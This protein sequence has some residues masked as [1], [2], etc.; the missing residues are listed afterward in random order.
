M[1]HLIRLNIRRLSRAESL[2]LHCQHRSHDADLPAT[3]EV[4]IELISASLFLCTVH[5][6]DMVTKVAVAVQ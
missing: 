5:K 3:F 2:K 1:K 4:S 6:D